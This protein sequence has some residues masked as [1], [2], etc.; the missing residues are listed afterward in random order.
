LKN[1]ARNALRLLFGTFFVN[2]IHKKE[3]KRVRKRRNSLR[4]PGYDY[5]TPGIYFITICTYDRSHLFGFVENGEMVL[6]MFGQIVYQRWKNIPKYFK[7]AQLLDF[8][9]MPNHIHGIIKLSGKIDN[10]PN[11]G[12]KHCKQHFYC[13]WK[14]SANNASP[15]LHTRS[16]NMMYYNQTP[17]YNGTKPGSI[18]AII[19][20]FCSITTRKINRIRKTSGTKVWQRGYYDRIIRNESEL[21][22][23]RKYIINN[24]KN[25]AESKKIIKCHP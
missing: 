17:R 6:N 15:L 9:I 24:P 12:V 4:L 5:K 16:Q 10:V 19:Q 22:A 3:S 21:F 2:I 20:N 13:N 25:W 23:I 11:V 1:N 14:N 18:P 7:N 8:Q